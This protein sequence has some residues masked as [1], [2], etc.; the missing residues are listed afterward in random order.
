[1][2][3]FP[4]RISLCGSL[5][6]LLLAAYTASSDLITCVSTLSAHLFVEEQAS[7]SSLHLYVCCC[8][9]RYRSD[10]DGTIR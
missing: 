4:R 7:R 6:L 10:N 3:S 2:S 8:T 1:M 9:R 5:L